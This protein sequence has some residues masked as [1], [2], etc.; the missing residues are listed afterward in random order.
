MYYFQ[1]GF[2]WLTLRLRGQELEGKEAAEA[3]IYI[4]IYI[5]VYQDSELMEERKDINIY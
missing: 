3:H 1:L 4:Y 5:Y 2:Y